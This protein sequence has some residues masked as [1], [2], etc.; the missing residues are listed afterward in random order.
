[1]VTIHIQLT[2]SIVLSTIITVTLMR[3]V[4]K[5]SHVIIDGHNQLKSLS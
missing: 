1:M 5:I 4:F 2:L 3:L